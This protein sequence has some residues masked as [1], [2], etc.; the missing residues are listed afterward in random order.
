LTSSTKRK[1]YFHMALVD[2]PADVSE[3][4]EGAESDAR[5][6]HGKQAAAKTGVHAANS[7]TQAFATNEAMKGTYYGY[8]GPCPPWNDDVVHHYHFAVYALNVPS[9]DLHG[10]FSGEAAIGAMRGKVL[11]QGERVATYSTNPAIVAKMKK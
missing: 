9:L 8:D 5:V 7:F 11:A 2:V 3:L 6:I 10:D 4:A 1:V